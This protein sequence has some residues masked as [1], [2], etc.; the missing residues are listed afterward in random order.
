M[1]EEIYAIFIWVLVRIGSLDFM[2]DGSLYWGVELVKGGAR[3]DEHLRRFTTGAY[4]D[5][6][7][8]IW[9]VVDFLRPN[10]NPTLCRDPKYMAVQFDDETLKSAKIYLGGVL[11]RSVELSGKSACI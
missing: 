1:S 2:V 10:Q 8:Q 11:Q 6:D 7:L 3:R 5:L 9:R 4:V